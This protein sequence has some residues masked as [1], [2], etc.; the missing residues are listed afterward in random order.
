MNPLSTIGTVLARLFLVLST[1]LNV[2][3]TGDPAE[4]LSSRCY[5]RGWVWPATIIDAL[6]FWQNNHCRGAY[7]NLR[8][9]GQRIA[10]T[11]GFRV[12]ASEVGPLSEIDLMPPPLWASVVVSGD[13][14]SVVVLE[15]SFA[16]TDLLGPPDRVIIPIYFGKNPQGAQS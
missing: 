7:S 11:W 13:G 8:E 1:S 2:I 12:R 3:M 10:S 6:F 4:S 15:S 14:V 9:Y 5:R 16:R